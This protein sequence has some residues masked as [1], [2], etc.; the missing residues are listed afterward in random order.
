MFITLLATEDPK[1]ILT[2]ITCRDEEDGRFE[3]SW[4][5]QIFDEMAGKCLERGLCDVS[6]MSNVS[7]EMSHL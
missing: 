1:E 4:K 6:K 2:L 5:R 7:W 3:C